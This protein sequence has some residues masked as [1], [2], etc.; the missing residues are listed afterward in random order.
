LAELQADSAIY[1]SANPT[2]L[3]AAFKMRYIYLDTI[4]KFRAME[5][6]I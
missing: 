5:R 4:V 3:D 2:R 1:L 6:E